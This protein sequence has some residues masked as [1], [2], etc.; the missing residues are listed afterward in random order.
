[1][2]RESHAVNFEMNI[3]QSTQDERIQDS[4]RRTYHSKMVDIVEWFDDK[5][6]D[7]V[8]DEKLVIP[9]KTEHML[10]FLASIVSLADRRKKCKSVEDIPEGWEDHAFCA[11]R[12]ALA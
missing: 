5:Y 9:V 10:E 8:V 1:M 11:Q 12:V 4:S 2:I 7:E 6:P 3:I